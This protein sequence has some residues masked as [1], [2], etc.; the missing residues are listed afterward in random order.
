MEY[1][2]GIGATVG[3]DVYIEAS[4]AEEARKIAYEKRYFLVGE[5]EFSPQTVGDFNVH[6]VEAEDV[7]EVEA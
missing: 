7:Q 2:V 1:R 6:D 3:G 4:S 5:I